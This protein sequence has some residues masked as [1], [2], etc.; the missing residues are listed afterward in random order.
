[1]AEAG[2]ILGRSA[3]RFS[4]ASCPV[5]TDATAFTS[6]DS[7]LFR[8]FLSRLSVYSIRYSVLLAYRF[9][10]GVNAP[11]HISDAS[12]FAA[13]LDY[14]LASNLILEGSFLYAIRN[15]NGYALGFVRPDTRLSRPRIRECGVREPSGSTFTNPAPSIPSKDLG[16]EA[17]TGTVWELIDGWAVGTRF[18]YWQPGNGSTTLASTRGSLNWD[19]PSAANDWGVRPD[20]VIDPVIA[21]EII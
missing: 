13:K 7:L 14:Y 12:V 3:G 17:M 1:M 11:G 19:T 8:R 9:G 15:S 2:A 5:P 10:S 16:W 6:T 20:R 18:S 4:I 21:F